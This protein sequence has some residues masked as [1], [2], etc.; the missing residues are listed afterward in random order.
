MNL[1]LTMDLPPEL[2]RLCLEETNNGVLLFEKT[3]DI[4]Y[5]DIVQQEFY[6]E[7]SIVTSVSIYLILLIHWVLLLLLYFLNSFQ[8]TPN[9]LIKSA[10]RVSE[11]FFR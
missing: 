9:G 6:I 5:S 7:A 10:A 1:D 11:T 4:S 2:C 3:D 8:M